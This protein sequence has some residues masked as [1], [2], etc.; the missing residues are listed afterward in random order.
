MIL[1]AVSNQILFKTLEKTKFGTIKM[2]FLGPNTEY[3]F[4][5]G[6]LVA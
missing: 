6:P 5:E 3:V 4:G 2:K 1:E